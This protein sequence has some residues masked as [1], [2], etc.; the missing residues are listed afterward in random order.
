METIN[1][2]IYKLESLGYN[3]ASATSR[4]C[5]EI[6]LKAISNS[7]FNKNITI[8]GGVVMSSI[9]KNIRRA[10]QDIDFDFIRYS[11]TNES[12]NI[13]IKELNCL[14]DFEIKKYG[15]IEELKQ[16]DYHGKRVYITIEDKEGNYVSTKIDIGVH[17]RLEIEQNEFC[18]DL[19]IN[20]EKVSLLI[21]SYEQML[22][23]KLKSLLIFGRFSTRYKDV[24]DIYYLLDKINKE[25]LDKCLYEYIYSDYKMKEKN[26]IDIANRLYL[27]FRNNIFVDNIK[28]SN[29]NWLEIDID[30]VFNE[31]VEYFREY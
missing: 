31:I 3:A 13:L 6:I 20:E 15:E 1:N 12:I 14:E 7:S 26:T 10:T 18:F 28:T 27:T 23:E 22:T 19:F 11:L 5:Q 30:T 29:K 8:K 9:S 4:F 16:Q 17:N 21:N 24:F 2:Y 25:K